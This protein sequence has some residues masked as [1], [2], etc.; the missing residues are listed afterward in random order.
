MRIVVTGTLAYDYIMDFPGYF[1]DHVMPE[2]EHKLSVS[3]LVDSMRKMRGGVAGNIA[4]NLAL[5]GDRPL[6]TSTIGHDFG[7]YHAWLSGHG[8]DT[9]GLLEI[10]HEFTSSCFINT[11]RAHNQIVAFYNGATSYANRISLV[12]LGVGSDDLVIISPTDPTAMSHYVTECQQ[13]NIPYIFDPG[14]QTPRLEAEHIRLGLAG[15]RVLIGNDYEFAMMARKLAITEAE[16][17]ASA[18]ITVITRGEKGSRIYTSETNGQE[19]DIPVVPATEVCDPTGAGDAYL[20][21]LAFGVSRN[22]PLEV[23]GR[24]AALTAV[25]AIEHQGCQEHSYTL[26]DFTARYTAAFGEHPA[27]LETLAV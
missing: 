17:I 10:E 9:S 5:L 8:I 11:D 18:P 27:L 1:M 3:F 16:L 7:D 22:L 24:I 21:G 12:G 20:A 15:A 23:T 13:H 25:Y 26:A 4:Y 2:R 14:K 19:I 6:I